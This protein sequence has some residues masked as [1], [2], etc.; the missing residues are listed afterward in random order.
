M[1][2]NT[3]FLANA[4]K[5]QQFLWANNFLVPMNNVK[6]QLGTTISIYGHFTS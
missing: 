1:V 2:T 6:T 4:D 5:N 3:A